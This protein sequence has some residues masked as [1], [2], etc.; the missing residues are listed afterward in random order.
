M[1]LGGVKVDNG[2]S[3]FDAVSF[4]ELTV[5]MN[6]VANGAPNDVVM[7]LYRCNTTKQPTLAT[8]LRGYGYSSVSGNSLCSTSQKGQIT[9]FVE[10]EF[11][12]KGN[13][14]IETIVDALWRELRKPLEAGLLSHYRN[15]YRKFRREDI[16]LVE[17]AQEIAART[18]R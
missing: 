7:R 14:S 9:L 18:G 5:L 12:Q 2:D 1:L 10:K 8:V 6:G 11:H 4:D 16:A 15:A 13:L 17:Q 3:P